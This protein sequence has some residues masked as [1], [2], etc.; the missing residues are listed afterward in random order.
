M[1]LTIYGKTQCTYCDKAKALLNSKGIEYLYIDLMQDAEALAFIRSTGA[2][3]VP[4]IFNG[5]TL[6]GGFDNLVEWL[7]ENDL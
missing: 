2:R 3:T 1:N 5:E 7:L 4:Q 6:I